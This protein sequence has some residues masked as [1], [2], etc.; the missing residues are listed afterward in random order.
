M[1]TIRVENRSEMPE[2]SL[3][4]KYF[5]NFLCSQTA[6]FISES[7]DSIYCVSSARSDAQVIFH[8]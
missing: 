1:H 4:S 2:Q 7:N 8:I 6:E 5:C 3:S